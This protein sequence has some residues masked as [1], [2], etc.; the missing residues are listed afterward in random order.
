MFYCW[1]LLF[2]LDDVEALDAKADEVA[3]EIEKSKS[4]KANN[5]TKDRKARNSKIALGPSVASDRDIAVALGSRPPMPKELQSVHNAAQK[6]KKD[7][8]IHHA[9]GQNKVD[10]NVLI[11]IGIR[12]KLFAPGAG[13]F[14][15]SDGLVH[16]SLW[17]SNRF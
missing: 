11:N 8:K 6:S 3:K 7:S 16:P 9:L 14:S 12:K 4:N 1:C 17:C 10:D 5:G 15:F 13:T 2:L